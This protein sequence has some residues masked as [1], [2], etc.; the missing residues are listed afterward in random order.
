MTI[1]D[2][3]ADGLRWRA[4]REMVRAEAAEASTST[5]TR[6]DNDNNKDGRDE[7]KRDACAS[8]TRVED[9]LVA[10]R[11]AEVVA[12]GSNVERRDRAMRRFQHL[13]ERLHSLPLS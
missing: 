7:P 1:W 12:A 3:R 13:V 11:D 5:L 10:A 8:V 2:R 4:L 9:L 6:I